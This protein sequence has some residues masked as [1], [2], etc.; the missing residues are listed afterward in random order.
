MT[1][2]LQLSRKPPALINLQDNSESLTGAGNDW[3]FFFFHFFKISCKNPV[4][5]L[6]NWHFQNILM[7]LWS[8][9][10]GSL[11]TSSKCQKHTV[12]AHNLVQQKNWLPTFLFI[13]LKWFK[14]GFRQICASLWFQTNTFSVLTYLLLRHLVYPHAH[15]N[16]ETKDSCQMRTVVKCC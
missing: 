16:N 8:M 6:Q 2:M 1:S 13:F 5:L 7:P 3:L 15:I 11:F 12:C 14:T 9:S 4:L 10:Q